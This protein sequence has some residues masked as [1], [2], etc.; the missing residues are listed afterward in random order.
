MSV[1]QFAAK[2]DSFEKRLAALEEIVQSLDLQDRVSKLEEIVQLL[3]FDELPSPPPAI[4]G[5]Q[6]VP[7]TGGQ[8][9]GGVG[10]FEQPT[11]EQPATASGQEQQTAGFSNVP[12][13]SV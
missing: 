4:P 11:A 8:G 10:N 9:Q 6:E 2:L 3:D 12:P 1:D 13:Q 7:L 5:A